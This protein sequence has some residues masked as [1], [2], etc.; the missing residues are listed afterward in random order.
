[1]SRKVNDSR[2]QHI[3]RWWVAVLL[4]PWLQISP[5][6]PGAEGDDQLDRRNKL[7]TNPVEP[8]MP[9]LVMP[10]TPAIPIK[11]QL[12]NQPSGRRLIRDI[13][14]R[15]AARIHLPFKE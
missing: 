8:P 6:M 13:P 3:R 7:K 15:I 12:P 11:I 9:D 2:P 4:F 1:M 10:T 14:R 5:I